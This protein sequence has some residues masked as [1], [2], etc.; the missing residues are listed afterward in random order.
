MSDDST[1]VVDYYFALQSPFAY[2]GHR[3]FEDI[4]EDA[5]AAVRTRPINLVGK[6]FPAT[7][8]VPLPQRSEA[9]KAYRLVELER[10]SKRRGLKM[11][12]QPKHFPTD[13]TMAVRMVVAARNDADMLHLAHAFMRAQWEQDKDLAD[14]DVLAEAADK[15]GFNG[16]KLIEA[17][18]DD[19]WDDRYERFT[20][21]AID[22]GVFGSPTYVFRGELFFGQDRLDFLAEA[23]GPAE[24]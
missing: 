4:L 9:R 17:A 18:E 11:N 20:D 22:R 13:D 12:V 6:V 23:L 3:A 21:Q 5:E 10:W 7:G 8:G 2:L 14:K 24:E 15:A 16:A 1:K 19:Q